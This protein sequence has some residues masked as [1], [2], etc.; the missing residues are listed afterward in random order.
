MISFNTSADGFA[1]DNPEKYKT[2]LHK[3]VEKTHQKI[4][5]E[6]VFVFTSDESLHQINKSHLNH[7]TFTDIITFNTSMKE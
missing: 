3:I 4:V 7:D 6:I 5:C 1:L 2:W